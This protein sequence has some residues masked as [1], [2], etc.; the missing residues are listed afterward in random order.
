MDDRI[1]NETSHIMLKIHTIATTVTLFVLIF[2][3]QELY[4]FKEEYALTFLHDSAF[5]LII[6]VVTSGIVYTIILKITEKVYTNHWIKTHRDLYIAG[7][8]MHIHGKADKDSTYLRVGT[9]RI[10]QNF[11]NIEIHA[12]NFSPKYENG[13][14]RP[15]DLQYTLWKYTL[16][17]ISDTGDIIGVYVA[18]KKYS[19]M[20]TNRG[21]HQ[22]SVIEN[23]HET[24]L[25]TVLAGGFSDVSPSDSEG[26]IRLYRKT[27]GTGA[28]HSLL[29]RIKKMLPWVK[30]K[31]VPH[32]V[33][34][35]IAKNLDEHGLPRDWKNEVDRIMKRIDAA[36]NSD[37]TQAVHSANDDGH[38]NQDKEGQ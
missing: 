18:S 33:P 38:S 19:T 30:N 22:I 34:E 26:Y 4:A 37:Q 13:E 32:N 6:A 1:R 20:R 11:Y 3:L 7:E 15:R 36:K 2:A 12:E 9:A 27:V 16:G 10:R 21:I 25:P 24:D 17:E 5:D 35:S 8:W 28:T 14:Y 29:D 31:P 23:D